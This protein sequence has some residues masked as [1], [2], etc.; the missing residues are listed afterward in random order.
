MFFFSLNEVEGWDPCD[1][2]HCQTIFFFCIFAVLLVFPEHR[3][4]R[5][6]VGAGSAFNSDLIVLVPFCLNNLWFNF[7]SVL[8]VTFSL[9]LQGILHL[10]ILCPKQIECFTRCICLLQE[11]YTGGNDRLIL[12]WSPSNFTSGELVIFFM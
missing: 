2:S 3:F 12:V 6:W 11:L 7:W 10:H 8:I 9:H 5:G 4:E 1:F